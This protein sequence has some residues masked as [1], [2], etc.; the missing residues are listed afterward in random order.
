MLPNGYQI[1]TKLVKWV[2]S[3]MFLNRYKYRAFILFTTP[4]KMILFQEG[5]VFIIILLLLF[6]FCFVFQGVATVYGSVEDLPQAVTCIGL[7]PEDKLKKQVIAAGSGS[8]LMF[9]NS[10]VRR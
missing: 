9:L 2:E 5:L 3:S 1:F 7:G 8:L 10:T 4:E 6:N